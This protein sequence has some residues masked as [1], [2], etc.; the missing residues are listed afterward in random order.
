MHFVGIDVHSRSSCVEI[1][2]ENGTLF[3]RFEIKGRLPDLIRRVTE[4]APRPFIVGYEASCGYGFLYDALAK[5]AA[6]V[7]VAHPGHLRL[8]FRSK[9]KTDRVDASKIAKLLFLGELPRIHVPSLRVRQ[10][11]GLLEFRHRKVHRMVSV[12]NQI[13]ALLR[14]LA[15]DPPKF[16]LW[17]KPGMAWFKEVPM[18]SL[19]AMRRGELITELRAQ[20][21]GIKRVDAT[22][23]E[24][25]G[26]KPEIKLLMTIPGVGIHTSMAVMAYVDDVRR[27]SS[28]SQVSSYFGLTPRE[29]SSGGKKRLGRISKDGP[30][31]VRKMLVE[32]AWMGIRHS[33]TIRDYYRKVRKDDPQRRKKAVVAVANHLLRVMTAML[34][35]G[36]SWQENP[37]A[38]KEKAEPPATK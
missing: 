8:I 35:S 29:D 18:E 21:R 3:K 24:I 17:S 20:I 25:A 31:T 12:K 33:A 10:W 4:E 13:R 38:V 9:K 5:V 1:L 28:V 26:D 11:R 19:D 16:K 14:G 2:N 34:R 37:A 23:L 30:S 32:A 15:I 36:Q 6:Q 7:Q 27:F 22:L